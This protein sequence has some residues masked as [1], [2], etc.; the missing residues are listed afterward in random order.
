MLKMVKYILNNYFLIFISIFLGMS[1]IYSGVIIYN[2]VKYYNEYLDG[3]IISK[4]SESTIN[5]DVRATIIFKYKVISNKGV[6]FSKNSKSF[7]LNDKV[8]CAV[9]N[10]NTV[11]ILRVNNIETNNK[12]GFEDLMSILVFIFFIFYIILKIKKK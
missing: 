8:F 1:L 4:S 2:D 12:Y 7:N 3:V 11:K 9:K 5:P 6:Y 10:Y